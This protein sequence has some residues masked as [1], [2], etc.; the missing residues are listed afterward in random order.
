MRLRQFPMIGRQLL[1]RGFRVLTVP[2]TPY[3]LVYRVRGDLIQ[4][5][6]VRHDRQNWAAEP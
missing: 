2:G 3:L 1:D 6:R 5:L 4:I